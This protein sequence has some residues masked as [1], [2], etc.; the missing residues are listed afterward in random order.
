MICET[1][2]DYDHTWEEWNKALQIAFPRST[3]FV[4]LLLEGML[5][6][7]KTDSKSMTKCFHDKNSLLKKCNIDGAAAISCII[8][9]LPY[10]IRAN[11]N[12]YTCKTP[13]QLYYGFLSSLENYKR[14]EFNSMNQPNTTWRRENNAVSKRGR[15]Q[16]LG[17]ATTAGKR[18]I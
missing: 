9:G 7:K 1:L 11:A 10:E 14:V 5:Q 15:D 13:R 3:D 12:A 18:G 16:I 17:D 4:D 8:R 2:E 6:R